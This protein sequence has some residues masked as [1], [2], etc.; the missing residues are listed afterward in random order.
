M[1]VIWHTRLM[2]LMTGRVMTMPRER[3]GIKM[4]QYVGSANGPIYQAAGSSEYLYVVRN[5]NFAEPMFNG[6]KHQLLVVPFVFLS[7]CLGALGT[8]K[9]DQ[10]G[11]Y[12]LTMITSIGLGLG[13]MVLAGGIL[14]PFLAY[15]FGVRPAQ[16]ADSPRDANR[17]GPLAVPGQEQPVQET[18]DKGKGEALPSSETQEGAV[19][20]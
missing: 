13:G 5:E 2:L 15:F 12:F 14:M 4:E 11:F 18:T 16:L 7:P 6:W 19:S 3:E 8:K 9:R 1:H 17:D 10:V 20:V